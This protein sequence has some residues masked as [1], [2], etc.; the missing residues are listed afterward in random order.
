MEKLVSVIVPVYNVGNYIEK[1]LRSIIHQDYAS[2][3]VFVVDDGSTDES[4]I[5]CDKVA[6][7][8]CRIKVLHQKNQGVS[9]ARNAAL[10]LCK[11]AYCCFIDGDDYL[12]PDFISKLLNGFTEFDCDLVCCGVC[13]ERWNGSIVWNRGIK[14]TTLY[15]RTEAIISTITPTGCAGW[16]FN[17]MYK[18]SIIKQYGITFDA[19]LKYCEDE[20]FVL[21]YFTH[22]NKM[23]YIKDVLYHYMENPMSANQKVFTEKKFNI[24]C[25]DRQRADEISADILKNLNEPEIDDAFKA[26]R[27]ISYHYTM[28][29]LIY[30]YS[31]EKEI[32]IQLRK[33]LRRYYFNWLTNSHFE[34]SFLASV[35]Y[36]LE[37]LCPMT[38]F[39]LF[40]VIHLPF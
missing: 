32:Y 31:G 29:K 23:A 12:S 11:G 21:T 9:V 1:C 7:E 34:K 27:F 37:A 38:L 18:L 39:K 20:V 26:R 35:R 2:I 33:G 17:K 4:G 16:P 6:A 25:L 22:I 8:D 3:E 15:E 24:N 14:E 5:I 36:A 28:N 19:T 10:A 30:N 40:K 13:R